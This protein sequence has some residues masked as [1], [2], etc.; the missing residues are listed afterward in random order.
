M[1]T[2]YTLP[3]T[4]ALADKAAGSL[5][6]EATE[7]EWALAALVYAQ[8]LPHGKRKAVSSKSGRYELTSTSNYA[9][10]NI[11][12][13]SSVQTVVNYRNTWKAAVDAGLVSGDVELGDT[14]ELPPNEIQIDGEMVPSWGHFYPGDPR[15]GTENRHISKDVAR[16]RAKEAIKA[17]P[18]IVAAAVKEDPKVADA[19]WEAIEEKGI[20]RANNAALAAIQRGGKVTQPEKTQLGSAWAAAKSAAS[21]GEALQ[22]LEDA[23]DVLEAAAKLVRDNGS[24]LD[25]E[26]E[27]IEVLNNRIIDVAAQLSSLSMEVAR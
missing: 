13:L 19:A 3:K 8:V 9:A 14:I 4:A 11:R 18:S 7:K 16:E 1:S 25:N 2:K 26:G 22:A 10:R 23:I 12:G 5:L 27:Q 21:R 17:D 20:E 6:S 24:P 15:D